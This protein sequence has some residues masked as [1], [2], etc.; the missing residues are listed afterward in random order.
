MRVADGQLLPFEKRWEGDDEQS[1]DVSFATEHVDVPLPL[2]EATKQRKAKFVR[3][4]DGDGSSCLSILEQVTYFPE[5][6]TFILH[7]AE[8]PYLMCLIGEKVS[9]ALWREL[10]KT[11]S[12]MLRENFGRGTA[13]RPT[14][15]S[16][17]RKV[18]KL[19][20]KPGPLKEK[21]FQLAGKAQNTATHQSYISRYRKKMRE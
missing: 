1:I 5:G 21:A 19:L 2:A 17:L 13:G 10:G 15:L 3:I 9:T 18:E 7:N 16:K 8:Q 11:V 14:D 6:L 4:D 20:K 12:A